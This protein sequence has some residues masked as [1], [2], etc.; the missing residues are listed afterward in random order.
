MGRNKVLLNSNL[1]PDLSIK[2]WNLLQRLET[3]GCLGGLAVE[4]LALAQ[5]IILEF[6]DRVLHQ[7]PA[8]S[9]LLLLSLSVSFMKAK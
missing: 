3:W 7:A 5:V 4:R 1:S 6:W 8:R 2:D 9:L